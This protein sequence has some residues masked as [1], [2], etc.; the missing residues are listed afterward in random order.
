MTDKILKVDKLKVNFYTEHKVVPAVDGVSFSLAKKQCKNIHLKIIGDQ[1]ADKSFIPVLKAEAVKLGVEKS[2]FFTGLVEHSKIP[3]LLH[4]CDIL[5]LTRPKGAFAEAG[6]PTKLG[7]YMAC[8]KPVIVSK[9]GDLCSYFKNKEELVL[10]EP[11]DINSIADGICYLVSN[12]E[13]REKIG[14]ASYQWMMENLE[15]Q[16]VSDKV[17]K[18]L[19][20]I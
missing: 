9:V 7:E 14:Q 1:V 16:H 20:R 15:Y 5:A 4:S 11:E 2:V 12:P 13:E 17:A 10:V 3:G 8:R 6:F 19:N 18:F